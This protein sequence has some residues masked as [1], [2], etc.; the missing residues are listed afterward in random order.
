[1][2]NFL[3][4]VLFFHS[5]SDGNGVCRSLQTRA[6]YLKSMIMTQTTKRVRQAEAGQKM[7]KPIARDYLYAAWD[8]SVVFNYVKCNY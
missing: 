2:D 5:W 8:Y 6:P 7:C 4:Y 3:E 1:M